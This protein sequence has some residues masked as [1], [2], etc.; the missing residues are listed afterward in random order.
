MLVYVISK[1]SQVHSLCSDVLRDLLGGDCTIHCV[2]A[3][4]ERFDADL[5]LWDIFPGSETFQR[6]PVEEKWRHYFFTDRSEVEALEARLP[7]VHTNILLKPITRATLHACLANACQHAGDARRGSLE[8]LRYDR[9][10]ILQCLFQTNLKL[11]AYDHDRTNFLAR[12]IHDFRAPLTAITGYCGLLLGEDV[13]SLTAEQREVIERMH[14]SAKKLSRMATSMFQ[15]S[16]AQR[17]NHAFEPA[18]GEIR[19]CIDQALHEILPAA[20]EKRLSV[21]SEALPTPYPLR[22][23][24][25]KMEQVL[26]NLLDN[27]CK[28]TP[29][30]GRIELRGYPW[31][32]GELAMDYSGG[33]SQERPQPNS[34]RLDIRDTGPGISAA[35]ISTIFE[36]YTSYGGG[37]DRSGGGLGL[38]VCRMILSQ[39]RGKIWAESHPN[40]AVF[41]FVVPFD[42]AVTIPEAISAGLNAHA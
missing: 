16:V 32:W 25:I 41:S 22:F 39:H 29:K 18:P 21:I 40:G 26:V 19:E 20:Q 12:A 17:Q 24:R 42:D 14:R 35:H 23:D 31:F 8:S 4:V 15:L 27:A 3:A 34:Y 28:F 38:A 36:E 10:E 7:L 30:G 6:V 9:D 1:S 33:P 11:Q 13:G 5:Y 37:T 2:A